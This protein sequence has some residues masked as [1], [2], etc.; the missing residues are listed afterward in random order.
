MTHREPWNA[1][2]DPQ[3]PSG[4]GAPAYSTVAKYVSNS[5]S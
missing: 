4:S 2:G 5:S 1:R 3:V